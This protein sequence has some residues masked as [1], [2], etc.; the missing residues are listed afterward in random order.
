LTDDIPFSTLGNYFLTF[1][2]QLQT[3]HILPGWSQRLCVQQTDEVIIKLNVASETPLAPANDKALDIFV[4][5]QR[6]P[7]QASYAIHNSLLNHFFIPLSC[8]QDCGLLCVVT[9]MSH[10][11]CSLDWQLD[12]LNTYRS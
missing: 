2:N 8:T 6:T 7:N 10:Y 4:A 11:R 1:S 9:C 12:L 5:T 3:S